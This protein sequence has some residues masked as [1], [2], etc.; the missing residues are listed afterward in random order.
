MGKAKD[1]LRIKSGNFL[2]IGCGVIGQIKFNICLKCKEKG[3][4]REKVIRPD[5]ETALK[6]R[7]I[8]KEL[9]NSVYRRDKTRRK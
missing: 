8:F 9:K 1:V 2:C 6:E 5:R 3:L 4:T 7:V